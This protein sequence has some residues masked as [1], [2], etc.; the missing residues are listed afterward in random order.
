[1]FRRVLPSLLVVALVAFAAACG[2]GGDASDFE[3]PPF[4]VLTDIA[5]GDLDGD[6][7]ADV[8]SVAMLAGS[9]LSRQGYLRIYRQTSPGAFAFSQYLVGTYPWRVVMADI[10]GDAAPD[11]LVLDANGPNG[12][13]IG[14]LWLLRQDPANRGV[15]RAPELIYT[16]PVTTYDMAVV[17]ANRDGAP[18]IVLS[19]G[20]GGTDGATLLAQ[21]PARRGT[22]RSPTSLAFPGRAAAVGVGD[23]N[24]DGVPDLAFYA[25][26]STGSPLASA[27]YTVLLYGQA[28][29]GYG[30]MIAGLAPQVG[31][32]S[33]LVSIVDTNSD[34][35]PDVLTVFMQQSTDYTSK[36]TVLV[37]TAPGAFAGVDST[38]GALRGRDGFVVAD[39]NHDGRADI[40]V[41]GFFPT[42]SPT[43]VRAETSLL[44]PVGG[45]AFGV[46][47]IYSMPVST[48]SITAADLDG[49]GY[50][51][52]VLQGGDNQAYVMQQAPNAPGAFLPLRAL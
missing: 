17:D 2:G 41:T 15:F 31:L 22:F 36:V 9:A 28:G 48:E 6:G 26:V 21:D 30:N 39:L 16:M 46:A 13:N 42:G 32:N 19:T 50:V 23:L 33:E 18:D 40:G 11:L 7:R 45:G 37:Q 35:R 5:A 4:W 24:G 1:M 49:D 52:L 34:G 51:D 3:L 8:A 43:V 20:L 38:L 47:A 14:R 29:G 12:E 27:G 25:S 10:D 44:F